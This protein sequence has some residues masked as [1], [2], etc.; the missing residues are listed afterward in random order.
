MAISLPVAIYVARYLGPNNYGLL[1][2]AICFV[3]LFS[4]I[5]MLGLDS[6]V[7]R[8]L[9]ADKKQRDELL[10]TT[11]A[12][13]IIGSILLL[14]VL[15]AAVRFTTNDTFTNLLIFIIALS[16]IFQSFN[17]INF[18]FQ[19]H[20]LSKYVV[21][22]QTVSMISS[23]IIKVLLICFS[24]GLI[25]FAAVMVVNNLILA[26]GLVTTYT[27]Y[28]NQK[29]RIFDWR[30]RPYLAKRLLKDSCPLMLSGI[31]ISIYMKIDHVMIKEMLN[32]KAVG[33]Y[34]AA[35]KLSEAWYFIPVAITSSVFPAIVNAKKS[36]EKLYYER[37]QKLYDLMTWL[38]IGIAL[39]TTFFADYIIKL[40]YGAQYQ[41]A[42]GVLKI[43]VWAGVFVFLGV[44]S[45]KYLIAENYTKIAFS[46]TCL[47]A[48]TN[49]ISNIILIPKYG[50]NGA[51]MATVGSY[52]VATF[53]IGFIPKTSSQT[54]SMLKSL[55]LLRI[56]V[57][58][59][60]G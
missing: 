51:A 59:V 15:A 9:V 37:L 45:G 16:T 56:V 39:P 13:K 60:G 31:A 34:A 33:N 43:Y 55:N 20:V 38:S 29:L 49:I 42:A 44:A 40:L 10:G 18:Y 35:V 23:A 2:Y 57:N 22:S 48:I 21:Y 54:I 14:G 36:N 52:F 24:M 7:I 4:A 3:G 32:T 30:V 46:R 47:G 8:D 1:S 12:L 25:Y 17:V 41:N 26:I 27:T 50:I 19:S 58:R 53:F 11:F 6:I 5:A 28:L